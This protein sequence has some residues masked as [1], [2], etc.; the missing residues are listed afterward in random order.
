MRV[1]PL[2]EPVA[3]MLL[4]SDGVGEF[5]PGDRSGW[6]SWAAEACCC[7]LA[8]DV[9]PIETAG[10]SLSLFEDML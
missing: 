7:S 10:K 3:P 4:C 1:A 6:A 9:L 5:R 8:P 2:P